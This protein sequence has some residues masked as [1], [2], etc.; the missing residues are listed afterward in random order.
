MSGPTRR[1]AGCQAEV[2]PSARF[3]PRCGTAQLAVLNGGVDPYLGLTIAGRFRL[4]ERL[5]QGR[6]GVVYRAEQLDLRRSVAVKLLHIE[7]SQ[8]PL[9]VERLRRET[10]HVH[11]LQS[12]HVVA[13][14]DSGQL[15]STES[16]GL[17]G[18]LYL[19][20][21]LLDGESLATVL[22]RDGAMGLERALPIIRQLCEA[23]GEA[24]ARGYVYR[25]LCPKNV[26]LT[27]RRGQR[28]FVKLLDF[29][30]SKEV[31]SE[32]S[33]HQ[34]LL[35]MAFGDARYM[36]PEQSVSS[37]VDRRVDLYALG[38]VTFELLAGR[39]PFLG[40]SPFDLLQQHL[41][42]PPP[43]LRELRPEL[44]PAI[45]EAVHRLLA[46]RPEDRF[47]TALR[48]LE[49]LQPSAQDAV[50][51]LAPSP[52]PAAPAH[53]V[54]P[55]RTAL[56]PAATME[57]PAT[58]A[59]GAALEVR[60]GEPLVDAPPAV[61]G[62]ASAVPSVP[63]MA[64]APIAGRVVAPTMKAPTMVRPGTTSQAVS[65]MLVTGELRAPPEAAAPSPVQGEAKV[66]TALPSAPGKS[67]VL[68][69][70]MTG[71]AEGSSRKRA[72]GRFARASMAG[73]P[74]SAAPASAGGAAAASGQGVP[75][76][77]ADSTLS[78][79]WYRQGEAQSL[80]GANGSA[81][82]GLAELDEDDTVVMSLHRGRR[83][84][85]A[86]IAAVVVLAL[87][88]VVLG[89]CRGRA[90]QGEATPSMPSSAA[91]STPEAPAAT[92]PAPAP[93]RKADP[94][95]PVA[96]RPAAAPPGTGGTKALAAPTPNRGEPRERGGTRPPSQRSR[97][98]ARPTPNRPPTRVHGARPPARPPVAADRLVN[99]F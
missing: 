90:R 56:G 76:S 66:E 6:S 12:E 47:P 15:A 22:S 33:T 39:G 4:L 38:L 97:P 45:D 64:V 53:R 84:R 87:L 3:C 69:G 28:D 46:K 94:A 29:G 60:S 31:Q 26:L 80:G 72:S 99:P 79:M 95:P 67:S 57:A 32:G 20:M 73:A 81:P 43:R 49:A 58:G 41:K 18:R 24:H 2:D 77:V 23:L 44:S 30:L 61:T 25:D 68:R 11:E 52:A 65:S 86:S 40:D 82:F 92:D 13:V 78:Q 63:G 96:P 36:A 48:F 42:A 54:A 70:A 51:Q 35:G 8:D 19:V 62:G 93:Q 5:E 16:P 74:A 7:S 55:E 9:A 85:L 14:Y 91:S 88:F 37:S 71:S 27:V 34:T 1:C 75:D 83:L 98:P 89:T 50:P 10:T 21:E 17:A 59:A